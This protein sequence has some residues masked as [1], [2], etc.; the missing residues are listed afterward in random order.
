MDSPMNHPRRP[1]ALALALALLASCSGPQKDATP[2]QALAQEDVQKLAD[3]RFVR[4]PFSDQV[5]AGV[6]RQ[7]ALFDHHFLPES[8]QLSRLGSRDLAIL[9]RGLGESG[10]R[11]ALPQGSASAEL[12][13]ARVALVRDT[14]VAM[15]VAAEAISVDTG[16]AG[17][18][19]IAAADAL[20]IRARI[21][22]SPMPQPG[23]SGT[24]ATSTTPTRNLQ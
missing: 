18:S 16:A 7:R 17:G 14:L 21:A 6:L 22:S 3:E 20:S 13:N 23:S 10:G 24:A 9:A 19:G 5:R 11:I 8:A 4:E 1:G 12:H 2:S 15:G